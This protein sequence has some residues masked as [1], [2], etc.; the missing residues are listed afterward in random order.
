[1]V[2]CQT[3]YSAR[4]LHIREVKKDAF[5]NSAMLRFTKSPGLINTS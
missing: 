3:V 5:V 1:M 4:A 2:S